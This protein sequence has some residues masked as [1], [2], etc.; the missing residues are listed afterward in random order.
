ME[1]REVDRWVVTS[2]AWQR[3]RQV[4]PMSPSLMSL[5]FTSSQKKNPSI[6][7][8]KRKTN[9]SKLR[10]TGTL[11]LFW[12]FQSQRTRSERWRCSF[13]LTSTFMEPVRPDGEPAVAAGSSLCNTCW[14]QQRLCVRYCLYLKRGACECIITLR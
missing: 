14:L 8:L 10:K 9:P 2:S 5:Y 7:L 11:Y 6:Q 1:V 4:R 3:E 13:N 12:L